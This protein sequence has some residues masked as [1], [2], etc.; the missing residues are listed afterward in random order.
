LELC[1]WIAKDSIETHWLQFSNPQEIE[2]CLGNLTGKLFDDLSTA[3]ALKRFCQGLDVLAEGWIV[4]NRDCQAVAKCVAAAM[5]AAELGSRPGAVFRVLRLELALRS[6]VITLF[7][8][9]RE[10]PFDDISRSGEPPGRCFAVL[11]YCSHGRHSAKFISGD[12]AVNCF[13][14]GSSPLH[15]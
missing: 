1:F 8:G 13:N 12:P 14:L 4:S 7:R 9:F 5:A 15:R 11:I 6:D 2:F 10:L 3:A